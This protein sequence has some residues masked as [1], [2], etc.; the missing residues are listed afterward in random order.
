[1]SPR[2]ASVAADGG[3]YGYFSNKYARVV[4]VIDAELQETVGFIPLA[5]TAWGGNGIYC[6]PDNEYSEFL[7]ERR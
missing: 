2:T 7:I 4:G 6:L 5:E 1:V 3:W